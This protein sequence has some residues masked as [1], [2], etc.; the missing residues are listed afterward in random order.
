[1]TK[2]DW[3]DGRNGESVASYRGLTIRSVQD[4]HAENPWQAWDS[5]VPLLWTSGDGLND[6]SQGEDIDSPLG[7]VSA[8]WISRH[9]KA[10]CAILAPDVNPDE[11]HA[12][13][14]AAVREN[15]PQWRAKL[16]DVKREALEERLADMKPSGRYGCWS[17]AGDY[18]DALER[19]WTMRGAVALDFQR[20][21]YS[22]GDSVRGLLVATPAWQ[23]KHG[24]RY[25]QPSDLESDANLFGAWAFGDVFGF[26]I[27]NEAGDVLDSCFGYYGDA[28]ESGLESAAM[29]SA[30]SILA[31]AAKRKAEKLKELIRNRVPLALRPA[32]LEEAGALG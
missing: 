22:Q 21:G 26:V 23:K 4:Q 19:L 2:L 15:P 13:L 20:N 10:L 1:M 7:D 5:Q 31:S 8:A 30:D 14:A 27:E 3:N 24:T 18:F 11:L 29:E 32:L 16:G 25:R 28:D 6:D 17:L 9:W 12:E